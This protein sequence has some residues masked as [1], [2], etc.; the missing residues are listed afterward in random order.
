VHG[1]VAAAIIDEATCH[2]VRVMTGALPITMKLIVRFRRPLRSGLVDVFAACEERSVLGSHRVACTLGLGGDV[3]V[4]GE[5]LIR[6][7][8]WFPAV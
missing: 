1:G 7:E 3:C 4:E 8:G 2:L 6:A 5:G